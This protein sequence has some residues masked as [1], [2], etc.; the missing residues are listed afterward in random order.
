MK[1]TNATIWASQGPMAKLAGMKLPVK[2]SYGLAKLA[3]GLN[4]QLK[5]LSETRNALIKKHGK[6][7]EKTGQPVVNANTPEMEAFAKE[8]AE[9]L[10]EEVEVTVDKVMIPEAVVTTCQKCGLVISTPF[11]IEPAILLA[12]DDF[13]GIKD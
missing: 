7:D 1:V 9:I 10:G 8:W 5:V 2:T 11:V 12:L 3:Q 4:S 6:P 13:I